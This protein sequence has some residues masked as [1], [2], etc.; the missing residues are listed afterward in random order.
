MLEKDYNDAVA[1]Q[2]QLKH[3]MEQCS[4]SATVGWER[5]CPVVR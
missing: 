2:E 3:D 4:V 5:V 1:K